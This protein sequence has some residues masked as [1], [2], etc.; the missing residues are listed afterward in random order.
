MRQFQTT[1]SDKNVFEPD[2]TA[3]GLS[4]TFSCEERLTLV[5]I[6]KLGPRTPA[7]ELLN[8]CWHAHH[9]IATTAP[10]VGPKVSPG[11]SSALVVVSDADLNTAVS[12]HLL[13]RNGQHVLNQLL[14][15][16]SICLR[17]L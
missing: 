17:Q 5:S 9:C 1:A 14:D 3:V 13:H 7:K 15:K 16:L 12:V 4:L 10:G 6:A 11:V 8:V 2:P